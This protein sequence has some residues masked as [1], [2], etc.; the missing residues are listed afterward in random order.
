M[1]D[2]APLDVGIQVNLIDQDPSFYP[3][4][5]DITAKYQVSQGILRDAQ[6]KGGHF[7]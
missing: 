1:T 2:F 6:I 7:Y 3:D 5:R 4:V